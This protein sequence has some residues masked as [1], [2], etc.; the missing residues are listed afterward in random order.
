VEEILKKF[1]ISAKT[2]LK[3]VYFETR[4]KSPGIADIDPLP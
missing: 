3:I 1:E 2:T 4:D